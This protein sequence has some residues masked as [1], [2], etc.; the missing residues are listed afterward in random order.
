MK[1]HPLRKAYGYVSRIKNGTPQVLVF[2]HSIKE[3]GIQIPK[4]TIELGEEPFHAVIREVQE[5]TG[6][7]DFQVEELIKQDKWEF[8]GKVYERFFYKINIEEDRETWDHAP[9]GGGSEDGLIF[10]YFWISHKHEVELAPGH[11]DYLDWIFKG[12]EV[13]R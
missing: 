3:S 9:T 10:S 4:G 12:E 1:N 13:K 7:V 8:K 11:G 6:L 2:R 5:E